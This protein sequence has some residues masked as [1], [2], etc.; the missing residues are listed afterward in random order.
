MQVELD[1]R[2]EF[3]L[4][5]FFAV[6]GSNF[7][8]FNCPLFSCGGGKSSHRAKLHFHISLV[9]FVSSPFARSAFGS[10]LT[11][12]L[13]RPFRFDDIKRL[14][15]HSFRSLSARKKKS[16]SALGLQTEKRRRKKSRATRDDTELCSGA[17]MDFFA[18]ALNN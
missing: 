2:A 16:P 17:K 7:C 9:T 14:T 12:L 1:L 3:A 4:K 18:S 6:F 8:A 15:V 11:S 5:H 10:W 13:A